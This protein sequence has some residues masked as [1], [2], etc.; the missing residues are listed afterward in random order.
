MK[1]NYRLDLPLY[2]DSPGDYGACAQ[3]PYG[4]VL[5]NPELL[6]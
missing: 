5:D 6:T 1:W 2:T 4:W 3:V